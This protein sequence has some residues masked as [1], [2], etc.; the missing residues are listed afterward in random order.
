MDEVATAHEKIITMS[1][2]ASISIPGG[3]CTHG[4]RI[5]IAAGR[6]GMTRMEACILLLNF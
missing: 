6:H 1:A 4:I 3:V 5:R 2:K